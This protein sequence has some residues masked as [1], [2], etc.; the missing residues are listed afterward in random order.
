VPRRSYE[1]N[2]EAPKIEY[3]RIEHVDICLAG[4]AAA[5]AH[6]PKL[7]RATEEASR[8]LVERVC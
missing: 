7:E 4:V 1:L 2:P 5:S 8:F 3:D 6:L